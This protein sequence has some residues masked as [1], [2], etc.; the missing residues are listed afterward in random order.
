MGSTDDTVAAIDM[1]DA[2]EK[3]N[4]HRIKVL[5]GM[6]V[7]QGLL[8]VQA[9]QIRLGMLLSFIVPAEQQPFFEATYEHLLAAELDQIHE[10]LTKPR[11]HLPE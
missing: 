9:L 1:A 2:V 6:G 10:M 11:L 7:P 8:D 5:L 4:E 3:E